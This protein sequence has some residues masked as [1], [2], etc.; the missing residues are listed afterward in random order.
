METLPG[1]GDLEFPAPPADRPYVLVNMV[2]SADGKITV[3]GTEQGLGSS[4]DQ[5]L[6]GALRSHADAVLNGAETLRKSGSTPDPGDEVFRALR[7]ARGLSEMPLGVVLSRS[8][9]LPLHSE[10]LTSREFEALVFL[11][12][13]A[14]KARLSAIEATGRRVVVVPDGR[15]V[16]SMLRFLRTQA[17][18]RCL[19]CEG[20]AHLNGS[21][22]D[23]DAVD[24]YFVTV[25]GRVVGGNV[26]L[27]PVR[28]ARDGSFAEVRRLT[29]VSAI[30]NLQTD[31]V[32]LRYRVGTTD[33]SGSSQ[34]SG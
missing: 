21:L 16:E 5:R 29:L 32:Y 7:R 9:D 31:E 6:M 23:I 18:V 15:A 33:E 25:G 13:A 1:Y 34:S 11:S 27:T 14:P 20:G 28:S 4:A 30:P 26:T 19:L 17:G 24:E 3:E 10:F 12:D 2:M 22:F 8:G